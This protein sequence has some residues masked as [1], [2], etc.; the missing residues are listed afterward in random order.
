MFFT[1]AVSM[2]CHE[3]RVC[4]VVPLLPLVA[5]QE[6]IS[7]KNSPP[8]RSQTFTDNFQELGWR[9]EEDFETESNF[10]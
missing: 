1:A 3:Q 5:H 8:L 2:A 9:M 6:Q 4:F 7:P 10:S